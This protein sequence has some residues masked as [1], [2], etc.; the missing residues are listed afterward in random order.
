MEV[1]A[2]GQYAVLCGISNGYVSR[3]ICEDYATSSPKYHNTQVSISYSVTLVSWSKRENKIWYMF[4]VKCGIFEI[5]TV[6][7]YFI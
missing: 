1:D 6:L 5:D 4:T 3:Y 2:V 7:E